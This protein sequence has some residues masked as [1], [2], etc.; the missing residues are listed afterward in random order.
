MQLWVGASIPLLTDGLSLL[1][2]PGFRGR[3]RV[4]MLGWPAHAFACAFALALSFALALAFALAGIWRGN[5][6]ASG[7][8]ALSP[9][10][11]FTA[12]GREY[13]DVRRGRTVYKLDSLT[14]MGGLNTRGLL[15]SYRPLV[16]G[17]RQRARDLRIE[18]VE[19]AKLAT[20]RQQLVKWVGA[21]L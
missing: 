4:E 6:A 10:T 1:R 5:A 14:G 15:A 19:G 12:G 9:D 11:P 8:D 3:G 2:H 13:I 17:D 20:L 7:M 16:D 21:A 18:L